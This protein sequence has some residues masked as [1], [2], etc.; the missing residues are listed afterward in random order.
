MISLK[1][2]LITATTLLISSTAMAN[3]TFIC[4]HGDQTRQIQV[5]YASEAATL[6]CEVTYDKG[7]GP[8]TLW[9]AQN[10]EGF[11]EETALAF[12]EKQRGWGWDCNKQ[13]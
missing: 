9:R 6:P 7:Q 5:V 12:V 11:C 10:K 2:I 3:E 8:E 4:T 13:E 1:K